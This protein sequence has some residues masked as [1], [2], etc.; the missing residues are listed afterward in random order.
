MTEVTARTNELKLATGANESTFNI[1]HVYIQIH[2]LYF[3]L[4]NKEK[5]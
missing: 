5:T 3:S 2:V 4:L 1:L